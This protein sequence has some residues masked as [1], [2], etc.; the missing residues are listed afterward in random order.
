MAKSKLFDIFPG[1]M[2]SEAVFQTLG[3][4]LEPGEVKFSAPAQRHAYKRHP[5]DVPKIV[6]H[7]SQLI[8]SPTYLGDDHRNPGKIELVGRVPGSLGAALIALTVEKN[9]T[10]GFYHVCSS[11]LITQSELDRKRD[12][13]IL[14]IVRHW[15]NLDSGTILD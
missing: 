3:I 1:A 7:L 8:A 5:K 15:P 2:P 12:K 13:G 11:Y 6:P 10:D 4:E 14:K 9:E